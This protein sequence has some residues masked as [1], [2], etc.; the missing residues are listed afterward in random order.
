MRVLPLTLTAAL[1]TVKIKNELTISQKISVHR[2]NLLELSQRASKYSIRL[3]ETTD[4]PNPRISRP[5]KIAFAFLAVSIPSIS[6][7]VASV[8]GADSSRILAG[9][10]VLIIISVPFWLVSLPLVGGY[11]ISEMRPDR[12]FSAVIYSMIIAL[13]TLL[14]VTAI[15]STKINSN[16]AAYY[17]W[18]VWACGM[19]AGTIAQPQLVSRWRHLKI[20]RIFLNRQE[21]SIAEKSK[22]LV[23]DIKELKDEL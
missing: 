3:G 1:S 22:A 17:I 15:L 5:T 19:V 20:P 7:A 13:F 9:T 8:S 6:Y 10:I 14:A 4:K 12:Y 21:I 11:K 2:Q 16:A 23:S 18:T